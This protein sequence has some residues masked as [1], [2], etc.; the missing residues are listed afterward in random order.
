MKSTPYVDAKGRVYKH[1]EFFP[2]EI[3]PY[4]YNDTVAQDYM[5][6][7]KE[8]ALLKGYRWEDDIPRTSGK[9]TILNNELPKNPKL[10]TNDLIEQILRC[11]TCAN[12]YKL[13][14]Q[15]IS[16]YKQLSLSLPVDC[17][18]CRHERRMKSRNVRTLFPGNCANC[19]KEFQTSYNPEQQKQYKIY[20]EECYNSEVI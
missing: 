12:N 17:F 9:E 3:S 18:N 6:L 20:C 7:T 2:I 19:N 4:P 10:F 1:G 14:S 8:Q 13:T 5:P 11:N 15:E 16:F